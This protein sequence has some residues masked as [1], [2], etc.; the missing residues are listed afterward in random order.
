MLKARIGSGP[1]LQNI[2]YVTQLD[3]SEIDRMYSQRAISN[4]STTE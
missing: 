4:P 2:L 3:G 1:L